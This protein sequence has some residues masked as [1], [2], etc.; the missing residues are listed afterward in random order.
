MVGVAAIP[1]EK[2]Q[3]EAQADDD[4]DHDQDNKNIEHRTLDAP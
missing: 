1:D 2:V 3:A 4:G